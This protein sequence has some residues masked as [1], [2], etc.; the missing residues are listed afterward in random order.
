[1]GEKKPPF[2]Q[3]CIFYSQPE[4]HR[5]QWGQTKKE[6]EERDHQLSRLHC[7][8][9]QHKSHLTCSLTMSITSC[10]VSSQSKSLNVP[11]PRRN[12]TYP[13]SFLYFSSSPSTHIIFP[14]GKPPSS[15]GNIQMNSQFCLSLGNIFRYLV[16]RLLEE[17]KTV[18]SPAATPNLMKDCHQVSKCLSDPKVRGGLICSWTTSYE[19]QTH[20]AKGIRVNNKDHHETPFPLSCLGFYVKFF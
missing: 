4:A 11:G 8:S 19:S 3:N 15:S 17:N 13:S 9:A 20:K 12:F 16:W 18:F 10:S 2:C 5:R 6:G 1:M 7:T 14:L